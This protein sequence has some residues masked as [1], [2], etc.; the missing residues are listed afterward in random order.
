[1]TAQTD[2]NSGFEFRDGLLHVDDAAIPSLTST[3]L[4][5]APLLAVCLALVLSS[6]AGLGVLFATLTRHGLP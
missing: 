4:L 3:T 2:P 6:G 5:P 1:M